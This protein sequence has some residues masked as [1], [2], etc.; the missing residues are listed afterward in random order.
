MRRQKGVALLPKQVVENLAYF[1]E[2][3][4]RGDVES[5]KDMARL[6]L[7]LLQPIGHG[8]IDVVCTSGGSSEKGNVFKERTRLRLLE[9]KTKSSHCLGICIHDK[10]AAYCRVRVRDLRDLRRVR[11]DHHS[12]DPLE[13]VPVFRPHV[14]LDYTRFSSAKELT[15]PCV[16]LAAR[17]CLIARLR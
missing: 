16:M 6:E 7:V 12:T 9:F 11:P 8:A 2:L 1:E 10:K 15:I 5:D 14:A 13:V 3:W 4:W 17:A